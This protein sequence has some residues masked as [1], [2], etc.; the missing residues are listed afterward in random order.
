MMRFSFGIRFKA[1]S[2]NELMVGRCLKV[3]HGYQYSQGINSIGVTFP[4]Y[5]NTT[6]GDV[7]GFVAADRHCLQQLMVHPYFQQMQKLKK[8]FFHEIITVP[9][10]LPEVRYCKDQKSDK[11]CAGGRQRRIRRGQRIAEKKGYAYQPRYDPSNNERTIQL[12]HKIPMTSSEN[13]AQVF[14][15]RVQR[16]ET[17][18]ISCGGYTSYGLA[19]QQEAKGTVPELV[20]TNF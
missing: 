13:P 14:Y 11:Y 19:N 6:I 17:N 7:I 5:C 20:F 8:F 9:D 1:R 3:L 2:N 10:N 4:E 12:F 16:H 15:Y 18:N